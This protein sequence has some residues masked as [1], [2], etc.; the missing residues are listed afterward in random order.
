MCRFEKRAPENTKYFPAPVSGYSL[1]ELI[2]TIALFS[3]VFSALF[4]GVQF[5]LSLVGTSKAEAGAL[6]LLVDKMEYIRSLPYNDVGTVGGVPAGDIPQTGTT[7]LNGITYNERVLIQYVDDPADGTGSSD[8]NG[9]LADY[10]QIKIEYVWSIRGKTNSASLV[11]NIVPNGIETTAGGGTIRVN[12]FDAQVQPLSGAAV[13]FLNN[14]TT[15]TI[16]TTRY[17]DPNGVAYLAGAPAAA[18]YEIIVTDDGYSTDGTYVATTSNP[19]PTT[20]PIA[21]LESQISTMNF[22]IDKLS[23]LTI[24][25]LN[26]AT[27]GNYTD[28]F[29]DNSGLISQ[30]STTV[31]SG[32][33]ILSGSAGSY[34][35]T[36]SAVSTST[37]VTSPDAWYSASFSASTSASTSVRVSVMYDN[38]GV[39]TLVPDEDLPGNSVGFTTSPVDISSLSTT[40][41]ASL[42]LSAIL[43]TTDANVTP[44]LHQWQITHVVNQTPIADVPLSIAGA[45]SIGTYD[46]GQPVLKYAATGVSDSSG[47][48][49]QS[50]I[51]YDLYTVTVNSTA[52]DVQE[53]CPIVPFALS[54]DT[55]ETLTFTLGP[56]SGAML[57]VAVT[58]AD[59]TPIPDATVRLQNTGI[60]QQQKTSL[61][62]QTYF[63]SGLYTAGDYQVTVSASGYA[64]QTV[65]DV[66]VNASSSLT[67]QL[68]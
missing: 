38:A 59:G 18:N 23:D 66:T 55:T 8:S 47:V 12:V 15:T 34:K 7:T 33:L 32:A 45:K 26:P 42:G 60:D 67:V 51:E 25:T 39:M 57:R 58:Q 54:P 27:Y 53:E 14:T 35:S 24:R 19:N 37:D 68:N 65:T 61:C 52:Y 50:N 62:G 11:S 31:S 21:V 1:I 16:D 30:S 6:A 56:A 20:P 64:T 43:T 22:Q 40:T 63:G 13:R 44:Y 4:A 2:I 49:D 41:Y 3:L 17:T 36:G 5:A 29:S 9:I 10:K 28:T 48:W 46:D